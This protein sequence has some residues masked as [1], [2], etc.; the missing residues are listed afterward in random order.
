MKQT[1][2]YKELW[3]DRDFVSLSPNERELFLYC[4]TCPNLSIIPAFL[5]TD[6]EICFDTSL[7][8]E[9]LPQLKQK[10][11]SMDIY[12]IDDFC[13]VKNKFKPFTFKGDRLKKAKDNLISKIP[14]KVL[15][16]MESNK[17]SIEYQYSI[18]TSNNSNSNS[19]SN[20]SNNSKKE[21]KYLKKEIIKNF[22]EFWEIYPKKIGKKKVEDIYFNLLEN[23][24]TNQLHKK[25]ISG[26]KKQIEYRD[27][28][29]DD[30]TV[31]IPEWKHPATWLNQGC[32]EDEMQ[33]ERQKFNINQVPEQHQE[34]FNFIL[35][36]EGENSARKFLKKLGLNYS[37]F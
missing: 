4:L 33:M 29:R 1:A 27:S 9:D 31:F 25:I 35:S 19:N 14:E 10:L 8:P 30:T 36:H 7:K 2:I 23:D 21:E 20:N 17:V 18:D 6:R 34:E 32:W 22:K 15:Q 37:N 26:L 12:F 28:V 5:L 3:R 11:S 16:I 13:I 24:K